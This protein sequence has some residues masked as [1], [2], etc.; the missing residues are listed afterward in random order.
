VVGQIW[1][2]G[3]AVAT[4]RFRSVLV[5][6]ITRVRCGR[7]AAVLA[8]LAE[9]AAA[10]ALDCLHMEAVPV[11]VS[12]SCASGFQRNVKEARLCP[13]HVWLVCGYAGDNDA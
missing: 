10:V 1:T 5:V 6:L 7:V 4:F 8:D 13:V 11:A 2:E 3:L 12:A 9:L